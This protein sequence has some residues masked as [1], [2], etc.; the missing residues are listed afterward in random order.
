MPAPRRVAGER[1]G[2]AAVAEHRLEAFHA[3]GIDFRRTRAV[4]LHD[5]TARALAD[6]EGRRGAAGHSA[7]EVDEAERVGAALAV[8]RVLPVA[9][10]VKNKVTAAAGIDRVVAGEAVE[11]L[12]RRRA[13]DRIVG[14]RAVDD[15]LLAAERQEVRAG[16]V[17]AARDR[18]A[19][20]VDRAVDRSADRAVERIAAALRAAV[21]EQGRPG[22][23]AAGVAEGQSAR[24]GQGAEVVVALHI[25]EILR[26]IAGHRRH[27]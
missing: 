25:D 26:V 24:E 1:D 27:R 4:G 21:D 16:A 11:G 9:G 23:A 22:R 2:V 3:G 20:E 14:E 18:D 17:R 8:D 10:V 6:R 5:E 19:G 15:D 12:G 13:G 7:V